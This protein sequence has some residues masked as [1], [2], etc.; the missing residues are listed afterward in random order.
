MQ[1]LHVFLLKRN[2]HGLDPLIPLYGAN[3]VRGCTVLITSG[4]HSAVDAWHKSRFQ[5][6]MIVV[7]KSPNNTEMTANRAIIRIRVLLF[8]NDDVASGG[9]CQPAGIGTA[10]CER[11]HATRLTP[12]SGANVPES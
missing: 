9:I 6:M 10:L 3:L 8:Q 11:G 5:R 2:S 7:E 1:S 12:S 4:I